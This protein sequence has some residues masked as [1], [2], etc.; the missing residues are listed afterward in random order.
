[1]GAVHLVDR[2][3]HVDGFAEQIALEYYQLGLDQP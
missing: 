3:N 1:M 2:L